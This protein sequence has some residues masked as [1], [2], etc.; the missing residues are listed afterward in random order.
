MEIRVRV[1][2]YPYLYV[3]SPINDDDETD[4]LH[5][6]GTSTETG[7][8]QRCGRRTDD[9]DAARMP[10]TRLNRRSGMKNKGTDGDWRR[11]PP[12]LREKREI[13]GGEVEE[14]TT[15]HRN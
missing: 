1:R 6:P 2:V 12:D 3:W 10:R 13:E 11:K 14:G 8:I 15:G 9:G 4:R 5:T 7:V